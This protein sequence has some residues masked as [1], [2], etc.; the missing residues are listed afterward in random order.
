MPLIIGSSFRT[1]VATLDESE[2]AAESCSSAK[3]YSLLAGLYDGWRSI[4][5]INN[6]SLLVSKRWDPVRIFKSAAVLSFTHC[7]VVSIH[8]VFINT[9]AH[10]KVEALVV[11]IATMYGAAPGNDACP[12]T[13]ERTL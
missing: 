3:L 2:T 13:M 4:L 7:A 1:T 6:N 5:L 9:P 8:V 12:P 11:F 10:N